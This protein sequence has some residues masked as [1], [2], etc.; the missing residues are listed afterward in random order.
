MQPTDYDKIS[1]LTDKSVSHTFHATQRKQIRKFQRLIS[2][3]KKRMDRASRNT[4]TNKGNNDDMN[5]ANS[6]INLSQ[7]QLSKT[8]SNVLAL[9]MNFAT[10]PSKI[11]VEEFIQSIEPSIRK[12]DKEKADNIRIQIHQVLKHSK[13]P[14]SNITR[15]EHQAINSLRNDSSIHILKADKG[16]A[17]VIMDRTEYDH[18]V[19]DILNT[20]TYTCLKKNP[21]PAVERK[22]A[23]K[24]LS[25]NRSS[26]LPTPLYRHLRPSSSKCPRFFG[27]PKIHKPDKPLRPIVSSRGSPTYNLA[28]HLTKLLHPLVGKTPHHVPNSAGFIN[29]IK[30]IKLQSADMLV[31]FD[32]KSLFTNV[33]TEEACLVTKSILEQDGTLTERTSLTPDQIYDLLL[34]CV[35]STYFQWRDNYYQ[36]ASGTPMG[37][38]ISPVLANIFMEDF[39][40]KTLATAQFQPKLWLR[41]VDDT[42]IIWP[43]GPDKLD[44]FLRHLNQQHPSIQFTMETETSDSLPFLDVLISKRA[45]GSLGHSVYRKPTHTDR[46]LNARSF[47]PPSVKTSV[48][49]TLLRRAH[50]ISDD[51][52]LQSELKH[53]N[54]VLRDNGYRPKNHSLAPDSSMSQTLNTPDMPVAVLPYIGHASH[55]IQRILREA[56]IKVYYR[57]RNKLETKLYTHKDKHNPRSQA[58]VYR[59][60]C[61]CGKV[62]IGETGRDLTTRLKEHIAHGR[63][64]EL[65]KSAIV[66]HSADLD[67]VVDWEQAEIIAPEK[68]W[69]TR[70]I[71]EAIEI[72]KHDT[73]PQDIGYFISHIWHSLVDPGIDLA[74]IFGSV[75]LQLVDPVIDLA[76]IFGSVHLQLVDPVMDLAH[77]FGS[78]HLQV[79]I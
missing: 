73:V 45:D 74:H 23:A 59:I 17:T 68:H 71:R 33:P 19:Q 53:L 42:F 31:S 10:T 66:K 43:H 5:K 48:N 56:N 8:E 63:R 52:H 2:C 3:G 14:K 12:M 51:E 77:I 25:L 60:P 11:P 32:V 24:L 7:R 49:R 46:Y 75:H 69:Y 27:Q 78:V 15:L 30:G 28:Q 41:Y 9:G 20:D 22:V 6:V 29:T 70:R 21:I 13:P 37:S 50:I 26:A 38:P 16:N 76:H 58:G 54:K 62:Y 64:G 18:K 47:H 35:K 61:S 44:G 55:K 4:S 79:T 67:H 39:E 72:H 57:T 34:T 36:Q 65:D 40:Q 1:A